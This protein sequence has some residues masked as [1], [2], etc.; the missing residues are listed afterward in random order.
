LAKPLKRHQKLIQFQFLVPIV[1]QIL[2]HGLGYETSKP[3][4]MQI[5]GYSVFWGARCLSTKRLSATKG[6]TVSGAF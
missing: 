5:F 2:L 3:M 4:N 6:V 1:V